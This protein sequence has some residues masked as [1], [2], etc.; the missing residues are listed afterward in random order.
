MSLNQVVVQLVELYLLMKQFNIERDEGLDYLILTLMLI[1]IG[2]TLKTWEPPMKKQ[3]I[4]VTL[5]VV[6]MWL[7]N[8]Q[9]NNAYLGFCVAGLVFFK[10]KLVEEAN[11]VANAYRG[12]EKGVNEYD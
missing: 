11:L 8:K 4:V 7:G 3:Y 2:M 6:G 9:V 12:L 10:D 1:I 5:L